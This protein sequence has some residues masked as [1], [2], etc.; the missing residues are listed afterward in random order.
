MPTSG[1]VAS[2]PASR[3]AIRGTIYLVDADLDRLLERYRHDFPEQSVST[4]T[5]DGPANG[6]S[7]G[8]STRM[9]VA[10][11][12]PALADLV[13][14]TELPPDDP[15][16]RPDTEPP[17]LRPTSAALGAA[18]A[19]TAGMP[20]P[21]SEETVTVPHTT[22]GRTG[23]D[24]SRLGIGCAYFSASTSPPTTSGGP[25]NGRSNSASTTS[26]SPPTTATTSSA[27]SEEKMGPVPRGR[28]LPRPL[29]PRHQ[30]RGADPRRH[31][32]AARAEPEA[33]ADRPRRPR[34]PAQLRPRGRWSDLDRRPRRGRCPR[35]P[36]RGQGAGR[37]PLHR[38]QRPPAP[39][40][41]PRGA[42]HRRDRRP[43]ER[44]QLRRPAHLR[45]RAQGLGPRPARWASDWS[46]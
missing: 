17:R 6:P 35:R 19:A 11:D 32:A 15:D 18:A 12:D 42:R 44:R 4:P 14:S 5:S 27:I 2:T 40:A 29:L 34:P 7:A 9:T 46:P 21:A 10:L 22:L 37:R 1:S 23:A 8:D 33:D 25:S 24:V 38:R 43:D 39:V 26:T 30:D 41:V 31:L 45:L 28:R 3:S 36:P 16:D 20:R 13:P